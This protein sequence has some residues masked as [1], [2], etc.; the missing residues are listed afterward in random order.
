MTWVLLI[1]AVWLTVAAL[2]GVLIGRSI[3][4]ADRKSE[5]NAAATAAPNFVVDLSPPPAAAGS[6]MASMPDAPGAA[7][8]P[9]TSGAVRPSIPSARASAASPAL[10][11]EPPREP[12]TF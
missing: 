5:E 4:L 11:A 7:A 10:S 1:G 8:E 2:V 3:R 6:L 12:G 9:G